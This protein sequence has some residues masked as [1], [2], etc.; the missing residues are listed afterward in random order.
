M[1]V[2]WLGLVVV[3]VVGFFA[4][5]GSV[6]AARCRKLPKPAPGG[7]YP[8]KIDMVKIGEGETQCYEFPVGENDVHAIEALL[9]ERVDR[10]CHFEVEIL[11]PDGKV[12]SDSTSTTRS[13]AGSFNQVQEYSFDQ[14]AGRYRALPAGN[15]IIKVTGGPSTTLDDGKGIYRLVLGFKDV[16]SAVPPATFIPEIDLVSQE[17]VG[18]DIRYTVAMTNRSFFS[19]DAFLPVDNTFCPPGGLATQLFLQILDANTGQPLLQSCRVSGPEDL[20]SMSFTLPADAPAPRILVRT[21]M[22]D[23]GLHHPHVS[24]PF[25]LSRGGP[26]PSSPA[27][28]GSDDPGGTG[29]RSPAIQGWRWD[30]SIEE[31]VPVFL[32]RNRASPARPSSQVTPPPESMPI[33]NKGEVPLTSDPTYAPGVREIKDVAFSVGDAPHVWYVNIDRPTR[34]LTVSLANE[35]AEQCLWALV[36]IIPPDGYVPDRPESLAGA[37]RDVSV[38]VFDVPSLP[39]GFWGI[40]IE[41]HSECPS[42]GYQLVVAY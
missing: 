19:A 1:T 4:V 33:S 7:Q 3:I 12:W 16:P 32:P 17:R 2:G 27:G 9:E 29:P 24:D 35:G 10:C 36:T 30:P 15:W 11:G 31:F 26:L 40:R 13:T 38:G 28:S 37:G 23:Q 42:T 14:Q 21:A 5:P 41:N 6:D 20:A 34:G 8:F 18:S 22:R 39:Q 25:D